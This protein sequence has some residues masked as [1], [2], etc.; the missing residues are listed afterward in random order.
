MLSRKKSNLPEYLFLKIWIL[1]GSISQELQKANLAF[2]ELETGGL[3]LPAVDYA[4][5][6]ILSGIGNLGQYRREAIVMFAQLFARD[7]KIQKWNRFKTSFFKDCQIKNIKSH[8]LPFILLNARA[9]A[10]LHAL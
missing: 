3:I 10:Y 7:K 9:H 4:S 5:G 2:T 1:L 6:S 8:F